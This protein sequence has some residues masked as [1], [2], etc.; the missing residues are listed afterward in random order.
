MPRARLCNKGCGRP[1][2]F[3]AV[4]SGYRPIDPATGARHVCIVP[5]KCDKCGA[6]F[7]DASGAKR[8]NACTDKDRIVRN[9]LR[10]PAVDMQANKPDSAVEEDNDE[11]KPNSP[12]DIGL[13]T[14]PGMVFCTSST[15]EPAQAP[16]NNSTNAIQLPDARK[17][18]NWVEKRGFPRHIDITPGRIF[19]EFSGFSRADIK[20]LCIAIVKAGRAPEPGIMRR[21]VISRDSSELSLLL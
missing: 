2:A 1:V 8:C 10:P 13:V 20:W 9:R 17:F 14:P 15:V 4:G 11:P 3:K 7:K 16:V 12:E 5:V 18:V 19:V 21:A 6:K